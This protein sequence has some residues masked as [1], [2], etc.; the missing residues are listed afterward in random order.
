MPDR[1]P[2][3]IFTPVPRHIHERRV[4]WPTIF[5]DVHANDNR[6]RGIT[7]MDAHGVNPNLVST[8][9]NFVFEDRGALAVALKVAPLNP[10]TG[11][12][13]LEYPP[14]HPHEPINV[15]HII[16]GVDRADVEVRSTDA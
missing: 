1:H 10:V 16:R 14:N 12:P 13:T 3:P 11:E 15:T 8:T 6:A 5:D 4:D 9:G 2:N 7:L